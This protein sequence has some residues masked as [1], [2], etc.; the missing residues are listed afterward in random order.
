MTIKQ[1]TAIEETFS[2]MID[3]QAIP[4]GDTRLFNAVLFETR[5]GPMMAIADQSHLYVLEFMER[6]ELA[7]EVECFKDTMNAKIVPGDNAILQSIQVELADYFNGKRSM[8]ETPFQMLGTP[9]QEK[10]WRALCQIPPGETR[11][12][13]DLAKS[14]HQPTACR[15]VARANGANQLAIIIPCHRVINT[16]GALGGYAGGVARKEWLLEHEKNDCKGGAA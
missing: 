16:G 8:F 14:I 12:Y 1:S 11:S 10:V 13:L 7:R 5:L 6:R 4:S 9:F 15:A 2:H 3:D